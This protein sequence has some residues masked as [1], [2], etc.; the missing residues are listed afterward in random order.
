MHSKSW[1]WAEDQYFSP[2]DDD[3]EECFKC[4]GTGTKPVECEYC[5]GTGKIETGIIEPNG[6]AKEF[7][8]CE[9]CEGTKV[10][11]EECNRCEGHGHV[12]K[13]QLRKEYLD[14]KADYDYQ[15]YKDSKIESDS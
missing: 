4:D 9:D 7:I 2:P 8:I 6:G 12:S 15:N 14:G 5:E 10:F 11:N 1:Q 3:G 13:E